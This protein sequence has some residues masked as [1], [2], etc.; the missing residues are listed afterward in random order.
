MRKLQPIYNNPTIELFLR[1][2]TKNG[3]PVLQVSKFITDPE[4]IQQVISCSQNNISLDAIITIT[5]KIKFY[6]SM[7]EKGLIKYDYDSD[8]YHWAVQE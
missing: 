8:S 1:V 3:K 5:D 6:G 4:K 2:T 7:H